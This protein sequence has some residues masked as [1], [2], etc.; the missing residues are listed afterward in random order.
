MDMDSGNFEI[1]IEDIDWEESF[2]ENV[3]EKRFVNLTENDKEKFLLELRD[4]N[5][6]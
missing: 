1:L 3:E 4:Q 5:T 6:F 2:E